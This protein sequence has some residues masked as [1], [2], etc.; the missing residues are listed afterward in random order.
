M[1]KEYLNVINV[2]GEGV[3]PGKD[4]PYSLSTDEKHVYRITGFEQLKDIINTGYI[5]PKDEKGK[6]YWSQ[7]G[8]KLYYIDKDRVILEAPINKVYN[9]K[10]GAAN[11]ED[12]SAVWVFYPS[13]NKY[14]NK[15][16]D[17]KQECYRIYK[18]EIIKRSR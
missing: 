16:N 3:G 7:G 14:L 13:L 11:I 8:K 15:I 6:V 4:T 17:V 1:E 2:V 5:K 10:I 9:G 18:E 12:L